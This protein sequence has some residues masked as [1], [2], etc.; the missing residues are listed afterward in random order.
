MDWGCEWRH[1]RN[2]LAGIL[3]AFEKAVSWDLNLD[4]ASYF[5]DLGKASAVWT[6]GCARARWFGQWVDSWR[7]TNCH[8]RKIVSLSPRVETLK[9]RKVIK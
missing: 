1:V 3:S 8:H 4:E 6:T 5:S 7:W 2:R 9:L